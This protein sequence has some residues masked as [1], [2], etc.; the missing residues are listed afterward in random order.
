MRLLLLSQACLQFQDYLR[1]LG[2]VM[3]IRVTSQGSWMVDWAGDRSVS[4]G[5]AGNAKIAYL[6]R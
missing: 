5:V 4:R 1:G 6:A 3:D 2:L